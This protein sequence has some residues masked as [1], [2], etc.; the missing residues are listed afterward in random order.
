MA[1]TGHS[2]RIVGKAA[3]LSSASSPELEAGHGE[4]LVEAENV[5]ATFG[6]HDGKAHGVRVGDV[7]R[8]EAF[9]P[10]A[11]FLVIA[12]GGEMNRNT[13]AGVDPIERFQCRLVPDTKQGEPVGFGDNQ[14]RGEQRN[15]SPDCV[16]EQAVGVGVMLVP[17]AAQRDPGTAIDEQLCGSRGGLRGTLATA[18]QRRSRSNTG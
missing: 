13:G 1:H 3:H 17:P 8:R 10:A 2:R 12:D 15:P 14:V 11:P 5:P 4:I 16:A 7:P 9:E 6:R 18:R